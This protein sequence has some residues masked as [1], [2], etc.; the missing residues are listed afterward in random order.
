MNFER[1]AV[2]SIA[3]LATWKYEAIRPRIAWGRGATERRRAGDVA[4]E[5]GHDLPLLPRR[6][7]IERRRARVAEARAF[8]VLGSACRAGRHRPSLTPS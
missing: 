2:R 5:H 1:A 4:E 3:T 8:R 7:R 6:R